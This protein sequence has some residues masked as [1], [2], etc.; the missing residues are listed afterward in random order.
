MNLRN[1]SSALYG[2][3]AAVALA[4]VGIA[5]ALAVGS[6]AEPLRRPAAF[7]LFAV[8]LVIT[9]FFAISMPRKKDVADLTTADAF[10]FALLL[11]WGVAAAT[12][13]VTVGSAVSDLLHRRAPLKVLFNSGQYAI[14]MAA[15][16]GIYALA[17]GGRPF[18]SRFIPAYAVAAF[19]Y[20][21]GNLVLFGVVI[22]LAYGTRFVPELRKSLRTETVPSAI[23]FGTAPILVIMADHDL[24]LLPL[25]LLPFLA[26]Y[27]SFRS[28]MQAEENRRAAERSAEQARRLAADQARLAEAEHALVE[29]LQESDRLKDDLLAAVSHE[30]RTPLAGMLGALSTLSTRDGRLSAGQ[31]RE[32]VGMAVRQ[33]ARLK[34]LIEQLLQ[35]ARFEHAAAERLGVPPVDAAGLAREALLAARAAHPDRPIELEAGAALPVRAAPEAVAQ[36]LGNLVD[37]AAKYAPDQTP[38]RLQASRRGGLAV[39]AVEDA[40]PGVP[41]AERERIF[42]RFTQLDQGATRRAG[43]VG[44][45]LYIAR[46]LAQAQGGELVVGDRGGSGGGA[47]FELRLPL[48]ATADADRRRGGHAVRQSPIRKR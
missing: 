20:F 14:V 17:G 16:G 15:A 24:G 19:V 37:N 3:V 21:L 10:A 5:G 45:G 22:M 34:E 13:V 26:V 38:I 31:R 12:V 36:V 35:A 39:L 25:A 47:R 48:A 32:L 44:L 33:G 8:A 29:Q 23:V 9:D 1:R 11:G 40:G 2:Y 18:S 30:L 27:L 41:A 4:G 42:A 46:R 6:A 43:G 7:W 28:A